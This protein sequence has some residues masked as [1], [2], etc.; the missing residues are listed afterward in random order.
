MAA[1]EQQVLAGHVAGMDAAEKGAEGA[2]L[3]GG[4]EAAC[5]NAP[6]ALLADGLGALRRGPGGGIQGLAQ[7]LGIEGSGQ[8]VVDRHVAPGQVRLAGQA[9]DEAGQAAA[10]AIG[11]AEN[12]DR[13][14]YRRRS[15]AHH[16]A[17]AAC[18]Q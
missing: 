10:R 3:V 17:E 12:V 1:V 2:E 7:A 8:Q 6:A 16:P 15:D 4:P 5:R 14:L 18:G 13:R 11:E 9:G